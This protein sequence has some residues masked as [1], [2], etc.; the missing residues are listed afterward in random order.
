MEKE[1]QVPINPNKVRIYEYFPYL[2][3]VDEE[4]KVKMAASWEKIDSSDN[5]FL[6]ELFKSRKL[7]IH[8]DDI[9]YI[10]NYLKFIY[11]VKNS[12]FNLEAIKVE[13]A[14]KELWPFFQMMKYHRGLSRI[15]IVREFDDKTEPRP[16]PVKISSEYALKLFYNIF[17]YAISNQKGMVYAKN[18]LL[19]LQENNILNKKSRNKIDHV[20]SV[21]KQ[22]VTMFRNYL[23]A[24]LEVKDNKPKSVHS[25]IGEIL[26]RI[27]FIDVYDEEVFENNRTEDEKECNYT[28]ASAYYNTKGRDYDFDIQKTKTLTLE[29]DKFSPHYFIFLNNSLI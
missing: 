7:T 23:E 15:S 27:G 12:D 9:G 10:Y 2:S 21:L 4:T 26:A 20:G 19:E 16:Q 6:F 3:C 18:Y 8:L 28:S 11:R 13:K 29:E 24:T 17:E 25:I 14:T 22:S 5:N 1:I